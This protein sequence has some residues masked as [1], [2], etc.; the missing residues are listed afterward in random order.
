MDP[1]NHYVKI[2]PKRYFEDMFGFS[3]WVKPKVFHTKMLKNVVEERLFFPAAEGQPAH[4]K[5]YSE[6]LAQ[7]RGS[8]TAAEKE[9]LE[10][11]EQSIKRLQYALNQVPEEKV[12]CL[13]LNRHWRR[14]EEL[15][16]FDSFINEERC[17]QMEDDLKNPTH[18]VEEIGE[19]GTNVKKPVER[20]LR[21]KEE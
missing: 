2:D 7:G 14:Q 13:T 17:K 6:I 20:E 18:I 4:A 19:E 1:R 3:K 10:D 21:P 11:V 8:L 15:S 9:Q 5:F 16:K 12:K